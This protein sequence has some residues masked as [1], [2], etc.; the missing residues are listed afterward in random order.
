MNINKIGI[1]V[2]YITN[3]FF[4]EINNQNVTKPK[5]IDKQIFKTDNKENSKPFQNILYVK[6]YSALSKA[7]NTKNNEHHIN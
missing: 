2:H 3:F 7:Y 5:H 4:L 1:M 6:E